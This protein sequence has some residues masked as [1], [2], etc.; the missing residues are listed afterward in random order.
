MAPAEEIVSELRGA[1]H[2]PATGAEK[3][4]TIA[5]ELDRSPRSR[6]DAESVVK[7]YL[8]E[9]YTEVWWYVRPNRV[10]PIRQ[11]VKRG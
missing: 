9:R 6:M 8:Q 1:Q 10:A 5:V 3:E 4:K 11:I 7:A 2:L